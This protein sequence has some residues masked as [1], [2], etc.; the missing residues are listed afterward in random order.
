MRKPV[1][2]IEQNIDE[3]SARDLVQGLS[4]SPLVA[5]ILV[6]RGL[7]SVEEARLFL[8]A[9]L[10]RL[11]DP[12]CLPDMDRAVERL[13]KALINRETVLVHGDYD[14][15]GISGT[16]MLVDFL[17]RLGIHVG[18]H[19]P[20]RVRDGYGVGFGT[21]EIARQQGASLVV[22]VDCG[23]SSYHEIAA[24][25]EAGLDFV[26]TDHHEP[27]LML[28]PAAAVVNPA[29]ARGQVTPYSGAG[30]AFMLIR[31]LAER[32]GRGPEEALAYLDMAA[33]G[34][35]GD[36]VPLCGDNRILAREG[37]KRI[38]GSRRPGLRALIEIAGWERI[39]EQEVV[40]GLCPRLNAA[41]RLGSARGAV[42]LLLTTSEAEAWELA[43]M[44]DRQNRLRQ[45]VEEQVFAQAVE[46]VDREGL[47][48]D[49]GVIIAS[50]SLWHPGVIGIVASRLVERYYRPAVV[51]A[52][53]NERGRGSA[54]SIPGFHIL[55]ALR[56]C[57]ELFFNLGGHELAAGFSLAAGNL[58]ALRERVNSYAREAWTEEIASPKLV[59]EGEALGPDLV[60]EVAKQL[61]ALAPFGPG[62]PEPVLLTR[63]ARVLEVKAANGATW[64]RVWVDGQ[65]H[66][67]VCFEEGVSMEEGVFDIAFVMELHGFH[68]R[69][70]LRLKV[71]GVRPASRDRVRV[72]GRQT[73]PER[74]LGICSS[75]REAYYYSQK[76]KLR[77]SK[78]V[79]TTPVG[80]LS[81]GDE[82]ALRKF[83]RVAVLP[84]LW[85]EQGFRLLEEALQKLSGCGVR[86]VEWRVANGRTGEP[87]IVDR[88]GTAVDELW[89]A[90]EDR[91]R[92]V[93]HVRRRNEARSL[94]RRLVERGCV[95]TVC[96]GGLGPEQRRASIQRFLSGGVPVLVATSIVNPADIG[97]VDRVW[98][99]DPPLVFPELLALACGRE[100]WL[101][102][103]PRRVRDD[104]ARIAVRGDLAGALEKNSASR[105]ASLLLGDVEA[106]SEALKSDPFP[107]LEVGRIAIRGG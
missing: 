25:R 96:H 59:L 94:G 101:C 46:Q 62:N 41:G 13:L 67:F 24:C 95:C 99:W 33:L 7:R 77:G 38:S 55:E 66:E 84:G 35:L 39:S 92:T 65:K 107:F 44:L 23:M 45:V 86:A 68:G 69:D 85:D 22:T 61:E 19:I 104:E 76:E 87:A 37:L 43:R 82:L 105:F 56:S 18:Y 28:P 63:R 52:L 83:E 97:D 2:W 8:E 26:V 90:L 14:A 40:F 34:T 88:R 78:M 58:E 106:I 50:S 89:G 20:D 17:T 9:G 51:V 73:E 42:E 21:A 1:V 16:A 72:T 3:R 10:D 81:S 48:D 70:T 103:H 79:M 49:Y 71:K 32:L 60:W 64:G 6:G 36:I 53:Q 93:I 29:L 91:L 47:D 74:A 11:S 15:D 100:M 102:Y 75:L 27:G 31:A 5:Q 80:V 98:L 12:F 30:V 4:V 54:R 57:G